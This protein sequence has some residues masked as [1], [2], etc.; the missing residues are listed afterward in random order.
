MIACILKMLYGTIVCYQSFQSASFVK[1][2]VQN[3]LFTVINDEE[4]KHNF[5]VENLKPALKITQLENQ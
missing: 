5:T 2:T 4:K 3:S 1:A